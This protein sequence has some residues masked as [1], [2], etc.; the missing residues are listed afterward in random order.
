MALIALFF[1]VFLIASIS[2]LFVETKKKGMIALCAVI[3]NAILSSYVAI[4]ALSG[5]QFDL[6]MSGTSSFGAIP[7]KVDALSAWFI[8]TI[9]FTLI[10]GVLYGFQYL[11]QYN[12]T[13]QTFSL[14]FIA[15]LLVQVA[16]ISICSV[17]NAMAFLL[18]WELMALSAFLLVIFEY[19]KKET[20][21]AGINYLIQ[22]HISIVFLMLAFIFVAYK[23]GSYEFK[24]ITEFSI[25]QP[26][27]AGTVLFMCFFI[28][29][30]W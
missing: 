28:L 30:R 26:I 12:S 9:N 3:L 8:L 11:K 6:L 18:F 7:V 1:I 20:I 2:I 17:Q 5:V 15:Y 22:S 13:H 27:L 29:N 21:K 19:H 4:S 23:T 14:H 16:L 25:H 24:D 10:T